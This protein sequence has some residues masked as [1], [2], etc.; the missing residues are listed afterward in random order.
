MYLKEPGEDV[1]CVELNA[2]TVFHSNCTYQSYISVLVD[3]TIHRY[4][5]FCLCSIV[6]P[7]L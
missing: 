2:K 4:T 5:Y 1:P 6:R 3:L 7:L